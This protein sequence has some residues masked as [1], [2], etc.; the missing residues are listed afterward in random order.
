VEASTAT[1]TYIVA[2]GLKPFT[3]VL[4]SGSERQAVVALARRRQLLDPGHGIARQHALALGRGQRRVEA[5]V[6]VVDR[7]RRQPL[8]ELAVEIID[9]RRLELLQNLIPSS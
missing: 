4:R 3:S 5:T 9:L 7:H 2:D 8:L 1:G 6:H